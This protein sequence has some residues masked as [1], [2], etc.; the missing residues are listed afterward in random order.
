M[1][2]LVVVAMGGNVTPAAPS[3][4]PHATVDTGRATKAAARSA[5]PVRF[6]CGSVVADTRKATSA[7]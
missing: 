4:P 7:I 3:L 6:I 5:S 2:V 1:V